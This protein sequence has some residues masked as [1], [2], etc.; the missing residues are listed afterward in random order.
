VA[1]PP[2]LAKYLAA[3]IDAHKEAETAATAWAKANCPFKDGEGVIYGGRKCVVW[4]VNARLFTYDDH[5]PVLIW[6]A[7]LADE[8]GVLF[9][10]SE[11]CM[12]H[13]SDLQ[14]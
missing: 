11:L 7:I 14:N 13:S 1:A 5:E 10:V 8:R 6:Y 9:R 12:P 4:E 2:E 3:A